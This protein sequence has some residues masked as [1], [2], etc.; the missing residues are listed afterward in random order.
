MEKSGNLIIRFLRAD[1][2]Y[3]PNLRSLEGL[4]MALRR[5]MWYINMALATLERLINPIIGFLMANMIFMP[6]FR[7]LG[8]GTDMAFL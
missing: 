1:M 7:S 8:G 3:L 5:K 4:S 2:P 6:S